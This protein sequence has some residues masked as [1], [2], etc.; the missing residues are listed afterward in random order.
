M[1]GEAEG[2]CPL[3]AR[4]LAVL[5]LLVRGWTNAQMAEKLGI[6]ERT[7]RF[8]MGNLLEKL[9]VGNRTEAVVAAIRAGWLKV[10]TIIGTV[11]ELGPF[12][13]DMANR[14]FLRGGES[15]KVPLS[16]LEFDVLV[17]LI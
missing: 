17:C 10:S 2:V 13:V 1:R 12:V 7:V 15:E 11:V 4:E 9:G 3:T 14:Q 8:H 6:S 16:Q 5:R